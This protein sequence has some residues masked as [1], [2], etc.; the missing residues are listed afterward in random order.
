MLFQDIALT[1]DEKLILAH[2]DSF[3]RLALDDMC[4]KSKRLV[5]DLTF[6]E[7]MS[8]ALK[9][10]SRPPLLLDIL[11]SAH[12]IGG[13]AQL[14]I[15]IKPGNREAAS[16]LAR[17]FAQYPDLMAHC[18]VVMSF[19]SF[20]MHSLQEELD[21]LFGATSEGGPSVAN[22]LSQNHRRSYSLGIF[23]NPA[24]LVHP[25]LPGITGSSLHTNNNNNNDNDNYLDAGAG[26]VGSPN[27]RNKQYARPKLLVLTVW[28]SPKKDVELQVSVGDDDVH[29]LLHG[30]IKGL[31]GVY[32]QYEPKMLTPEGQAV[33]SKLAR[34]Y[35]VG[36]WN[37][38]RPQ[39][40]DDYATFSTLVQQGKVSYVNTDLPREFFP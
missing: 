19:D 34:R 38:H 17:L 31:D 2:D 4:E 23:P 33:L 24:P 8:V 21:V 37:H 27:T 40:P 39:D 6:Q 26:P 32:M 30:W 14:I 10:G 12:A 18:A 16:A 35:H 3:V 25:I 15:E 36:V 29:K 1:K 9:S 5:R 28:E 13:N 20:A 11:Q 22:Q 7:I